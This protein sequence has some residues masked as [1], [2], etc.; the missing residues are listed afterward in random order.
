M[1]QNTIFSVVNIESTLVDSDVSGVKKLSNIILVSKSNSIGSRAIVFGSSYICHRYGSYTSNRS[2]R[3][4]QKRSKKCRCTARF[5]VT[6]FKS[7]PDVIAFEPISDLLN[8]IFGDDSG[9]RTLPLAKK[10]KDA[11]ENIFIYL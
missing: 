3:P 5:K 11:I 7:N 6:C 1:S 8:H 4:I 10:Y 9:I 2:E